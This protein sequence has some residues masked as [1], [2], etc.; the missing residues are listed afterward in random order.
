MSVVKESI[1]TY[2][3]NLSDIFNN[4]IRTST[5]PEIHKETEVTPVYKKVI[6]HQKQIFAQQVLSNFS[7]IFKKH[8]C[9][10]V[11]KHMQNKF[12][13]NLTRFR[14]NRG[15]QHALFKMIETWKTKLNMSHKVGVIYM[16][17]SKAFDSLIH[18]L[19][20]SKL[21]FYGLDQHAVEFFRNYLSNC[22]QCFKTNN[23]LGN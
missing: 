20:I 12:S 6:P 22:Y 5:F 13:I 16:N 2:Y 11:N 18:K 4:C 1:S 14:K 15:T 21:E 17:I 10:Q 23:I 3:G 7:K 9:L 8:I 19:L